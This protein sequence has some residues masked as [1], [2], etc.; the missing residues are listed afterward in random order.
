MRRK[1]CPP[2]LCY[3]LL[4]LF[5]IS[6]PASAQTTAPSDW[7]WMGGSSTVGSSCSGA[8][9][10]GQAGVYGTLGTPAAGN[11][12]GSRIYAASWT[13][14]SGHF[15]LFGGIG[16]DANGQGGGLNDLWEFNPSTNEWAW[17]GGSS[18]VNP[19]SV[20]GTLGTPAPGNNPGPRAEGVTWTDSKGNVWL[21]G[22]GNLNDFWEFDLSTNEWAWMG[23]SI[24]SA[25]Y[26]PPGSYGTLGTP[27][28]GNIPGC[29]NLAI[30]W[31]DSNGNFWLFGGGATNNNGYYG[32][33]NDLWEFNPST[34]EWAWMGGSVGL[35]KPGTYGTLGVPST[36]NIPGSDAGASAW[37]DSAGNLW[38][39]GS[40]YN[41]LWE[42]NPSTN[43]W[44]WMGGSD[45][46]SQGGVYGTL[47]APSTGNIPGARGLTANWTDSNG[48]LWL[49][50]GQGLDA[51]GKN[52]MLNDLWKFDP[53]TNKWAWMGG[54]ST[55][56]CVTCYCGQPGVYGTL[57]TPASGNLP[58]GR[59]PAATWTDSNGNFWV[60][61]GFAED[62]N[63]TLG[64]LN[65]LWEYEPPAPGVS[66]PLI[67]WPAPAPI[68]YGT[69]LSANQLDATS[70][71][72]GRFTYTPPAG[73]VLPPG[74]HTLSVT[75][76]PADATDF[77][78]ATATVTVMVNSAP[79][80]S[81][82]TTSIAFGS[83]TVGN[84]TA[85]QDVTLTNTGQLTLSIAGISLTGANASS[86]VF[87]NNC[88]TGLAAGANCSI[89]GHFAPAAGGALTAAVAITDNAYGSPQSIALS[90]TGLQP[91]VTLS[92]TRLSY[93]SFNVGTNSNSQ[94][95]TMTNTG[96]AALSITSI[97]LT[98]AD[99]SSF[100]FAN[101]CTGSMAV[102][103]SCTIHG[104]F[105]P[106]TGGELTA[107]ITITDNASGSP[108]TIALSGTGVAP[109]LALSAA[110]LSFAA[111]TVGEASGSES[112]ALTN[113]SGAAVPI[114]SVAVTGADASSFVFANNCGTNLAVGAS[115]T[116]HGHFEPA[117]TGALTAAI[118][119][120]DSATTFP[121]SIA[122]S[123]TGLSAALATLSATSLS[124]GLVTVGTSS[125]SQYVTMTNTGSATL[126]F[127][128][129]ALTGADASSFVFA[130]NCGAALAPGASCTI[131]GH[132]APVTTGAQAA[133]VTI[134]DSAA[135]SPQSIALSGTG[136]QAPLQ[137]PAAALPLATIGTPF[138]F[139]FSARGGIPPYT[140]NFNGIGPDPGLQLAS[141]G[142]LSGT[143]TLASSCSTG[144]SSFWYGADT[145]ILF[146]VKVTDAV[147]QSAVQQFCMGTYLPAPVVSSITPGVVTADGASHTITV[148]GSNFTPTSEVF[149]G[150]GSKVTALFVDSGHLTIKLVP[151][152]KGLFAI[153]QPS[154]SQVT[155]LDSAVPTWVVQPVANAGNMNESFTI[156]DPVPTV[157]SISAVLDNT[158]SPCAPGLYC[159]L[160]IDGT[161]FVFDSQIQIVKSASLAL[162]TLPGTIPPWNSVSSTPF[163]IS[164]PGW[165][166]V[167]ITNPNQAGG[168]I[169][170]TQMHFT[171][172]NLFHSSPP[173]G[174][175]FEPGDSIVAGGQDGDFLDTTSSFLQVLSGVTTY[176]LGLPGTTS[177]QIA[178]GI[179]AESTNA[180]GAVTIPA[181]TQ[182]S[183]CTGVG[184]SFPSGQ[185][186]NVQLIGFG[187]YNEY[188][189]YLPGTLGGVSGIL[190]CVTW[191][192]TTG[193]GYI[194]TPNTIT[195][196]GTFTAP[197]WQTDL[198]VAGINTGTCVIQ[199]GNNNFGSAATVEADITAMMAMP[200]AKRGALQGLLYDNVPQ[201][202][203]GGG[204]DRDA[205]SALN[206]WETSMFSGQAV[207]I[208]ALFAT[209]VC[210]LAI[211]QADPESVIDCGHGVMPALFRAQDVT[212]TITTDINSSTCTIPV[213]GL[214]GGG[215]PDFGK[216][217]TM[218]IGNEKVYVSTNSGKTVTGCVRGYASTTA[219][220]HRA[221]QA[222]TAID[223]EHPSGQGYQYIAEW[224]LAAI[225]A[226][227]Q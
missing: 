144:G 183:S 87:G 226:Q 131:H 197:T 199:G 35:N 78:T 196:G 97:N 129:I 58:G 100:V 138:S 77:T 207:D 83:T 98:G 24:P 1:Y 72:A 6:L 41:V 201:V 10:C 29:R 214:T 62:A 128:S 64:F 15:W 9:W 134:T 5:A 151:T 169:A 19:S 124:F 105:A 188:Q 219:A 88:G 203:I 44:A 136:T 111:T 49:F 55:V 118:S 163:K 140:W 71:V 185:N 149:V 212:G 89:H 54:N 56:I 99:E 160:I 116:I 102:G 65:D 95:V 143:P 68:P 21:F 220:S 16:Y 76:T 211:V 179:G 81:L 8:N 74:S 221:G 158:S 63:G 142:T 107:A 210:P 217:V 46:A 3:S 13:D 200:C 57:G 113:T 38:L 52:G 159:Q 215:A 25:D 51:D 150:S 32:N 204:A 170:S 153:N 194:F 106:Q 18:S 85:S 33:R 110:S 213:T 152:S 2:V 96:S 70:T 27:A 119:I 218:T 84:A 222:F 173:L 40:G 148:A 209:E 114:T 216:G 154:S 147:N 117:A 93:G 39:F 174:P 11:V 223:A 22:G 42:F 4:L 103:A 91:S 157:T 92:A 130:N 164:G 69:P 127:S 187:N 186:P 145:S 48:Q 53:S 121:Q 75:F 156:A 123:G 45:G 168:G 79:V 125:V 94:S 227:Q 171:L 192:R 126:T 20:Y 177:T 14:T 182:A 135:G 59:Q 90:G 17:M 181:C 86:F 205:L 206:A 60:F 195:S 82:S 73:T 193:T 166:D 101:D 146:D 80:A 176:N 47:G 133:A 26:C 161:G 167:T 137:L 43:E 172:S 155:F 165:Y 208:E 198:S 37:T 67:T 141:N 180:V 66:V 225:Q 190:T 139:S 31:T 61:G 202:W 120:T 28:A 189:S 132:F 175:I 109:A 36:G 104:H 184:V 112:V 30:G 122:L 191:C 224:D 50:G 34:N 162:A 115:C 108:Q 7:T 12:P 178:I 23:G